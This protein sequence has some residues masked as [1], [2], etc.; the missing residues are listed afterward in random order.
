MVSLSLQYR[1]SLF[2]FYTQILSDIKISK[3]KKKKKKKKK[4]KTLPM[5]ITH[6]KKI[7]VFSISTVHLVM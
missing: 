6:S 4:K 2:I 7:K 3:I 1:Y 5:E